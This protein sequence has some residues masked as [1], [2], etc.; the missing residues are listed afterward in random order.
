M[1]ESEPTLKGLFHDAKRDQDELNSLDP[2]IATF[3]ETLQSII[4]KLQRCRQL[5]RQLSLF[6]KNEEIEDISTQDLQ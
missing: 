4:D 3:K 1:D 5:I 6:S 2:R